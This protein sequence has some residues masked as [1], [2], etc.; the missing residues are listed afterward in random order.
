M[1]HPIRGVKMIRNK[2][3]E[4][5]YSLSDLTKE[6]VVPGSMTVKLAYAIKRN[7][8]L[9]EP[10]VKDIEKTTSEMTSEIEGIDD[11]DA[12]RK[13]LCSE[14]ADKNED[15]TPVIE[16]NNYRIKERK[17]QFE[18]KIEELYK[19]Y[20]AI[21]IKIDEV[22]KN[23]AAFMSEDETIEIHTIPIAEILDAYITPARMEK[24][25]NIIE[26]N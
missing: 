7:I 21:M 12:E 25:Y 22:N 6:T 5:Y 15:G 24:L 17:D 9:L 13:A 11:F 1:L 18:I 4:L 2:I 3:I 19:K 14:Y 26:Q 16:N 8:T 23:I 20:P 10:I